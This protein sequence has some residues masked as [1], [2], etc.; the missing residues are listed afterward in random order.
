[1]L[2][3]IAPATGLLFTLENILWI[4]IG[5]FVGAVFAA[6]PG[7]SVILCVILFLPV[8]YTMTAIPG[9]MF[10]LGIYCAGG[11]GGSVSAILINTP[12]TPHAAATMLDGHPLSQQGRTKAALKI[13]LYASTFGGIFSALMLLFLGPQ[14]AKVAA[15]LGTA[16]YFMV[17]VFGLT[18]IAGVSGKS[19]IRGLVSACLG[20]LISCVGTD[21]MTSYD[22][23]TFGIPRLYLGLDLAVCLIGLFA[24]VEILA[25][26]EKK[27][28]D[29][30]MDTRK[31]KDD[32][33]ITHQEYK[34]MARPVLM[35]SI[36]GVLVGI[37]PG[38]GASEASWFSYNTAKNLSKHPEEFGHGSVEGIAAAESANN[39]VTGATLIPLLTLG[40]PGDG[41]VAI[42]LSALMINGLNP[43]LSLF[44]TDGDIMYAIML[45]LILVNLFMFLQ[46]KFLTSLF[47]KVVSIP[48]EILTP[49]I[50]IF[51]FAGAYSVNEN[52]F[53]VAVALVFGV[54]AWVLRKLDLPPVPILLGLV[55]GRMT[56][57]NFRRALLISNGDPSIFVQSIYCKI[58]LALIIVAV[59]AIIR[60]KLK[61]QKAAKAAASQ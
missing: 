43:G 38:T 34:R 16:E 2:Q 57:T 15:Q 29:L 17:C 5:V 6:I 45:G 21:P 47:A 30:H 48:Q 9:M 53:D 25:K 12:G 20:L 59:A 55:L 42:M 50:V 4:N 33:K 51:C 1:M 22:R 14:V 27:R 58:F 26:V 10:L 24:L 18:I 46:G 23:F 39:A 61:E 54:L 28:G 32:G 44:T 49:I 40:I 8:T 7:L 36:I 35:S 52:Y 37:I 3:Y 31:I 56:E 11:Y 60:G 19:I 41:T 13:A